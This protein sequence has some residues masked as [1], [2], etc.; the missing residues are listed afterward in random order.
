MSNRTNKTID[1]RHLS[2]ERRSCEVQTDEVY[3]ADSAALAE[4]I[5]ELVADGMDHMRAWST[6]MS[7]LGRDHLFR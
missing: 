7:D 1:S 3:E 5:N 6:V 4:L 2:A